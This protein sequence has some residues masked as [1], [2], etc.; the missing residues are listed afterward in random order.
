[1]GVLVALGLLKLFF[2]RMCFLMVTLKHC[3]GATYDMVLILLTMLF[4]E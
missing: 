2:H 1:M 3:Q 4:G